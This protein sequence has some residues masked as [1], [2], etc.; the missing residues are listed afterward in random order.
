[1]N[2]SAGGMVG[3]AETMDWWG[4]CILKYVCQK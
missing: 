4:G 1:M 3:A 2:S